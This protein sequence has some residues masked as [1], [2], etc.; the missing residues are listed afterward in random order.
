MNN[1]N[2][3]LPDAISSYVRWPSLFFSYIYFVYRCGVFV[4]YVCLLI[5]ELYFSEKALLIWR[6]RC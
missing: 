1:R 5:S 2:A 6:L 3:A 4:I